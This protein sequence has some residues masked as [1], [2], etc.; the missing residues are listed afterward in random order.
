MD[1]GVILQD[2]E[3]ILF[4]VMYMSRKLIPREDALSTIEKE[5]L[6]IVWAIEKLQRFLYDRE[7]VLETYH[8]PLVY[9]NRAKLTNPKL[10]R[11]ALL[12]QP[13]SFKIE[14][15]KGTTNT[16]ADGLSRQYE[17][18]PPLQK[19]EGDLL[20]SGHTHDHTL[21]KKEKEIGKETKE[22]KEDQNN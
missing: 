5:C 14:H 19:G 8:A 11:W 16:N 9:L 18:I 6:A 15:K 12:L 3:G 21:P 13:Y 2:H 4:P 1:Y 22:R 20:G 10:M 7:F 17:D